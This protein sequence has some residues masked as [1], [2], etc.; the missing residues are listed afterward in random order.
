MADHS[1]TASATEEHGAEHPGF[2]Q[3]L[4]EKLHLG[5]KH[6]DAKVGGEAEAPTHDAP[7]VTK[8]TT[9]DH[10]AKPADVVAPKSTSGDRVAKP[11]AVAVP[12]MSTDAAPEEQQFY[13]ARS[14]ATPDMAS[15]AG[16]E[17]EHHGGVPTFLAALPDHDVPALDSPTHP[18]LHHVAES[19]EAQQGEHHGHVPE[20]AVPTF[21]ASLPDQDIPAEDAQAHPQLHHGTESKELHQGEHHGVVPDGG[22]PTFLAALPDQ[23]IR[24]HQELHHVQQVEHGAP[25]G[26]H[27]G[28]VPTFLA[29]LPDQD[30]PAQDTPTHP[31]LHHVAEQQQ[32]EEHH[33]QVPEDAVPTFLAALPD[34]DIP[35]EDA[36]AHKELHHVEHHHQGPGGPAEV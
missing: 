13:D 33:G 10:V 12:P 11:A 28:G 14:S 3:K 31:E 30:V 35:A 22:V 8:S 1:A 23:D 20:D 32:Q 36:P 19:K 24:A 26:E 4:K 6:K 34:Q 7:V 27:H 2:L 15:L 21:L 17:S 16:H 5:H 29:T 18:E 9:A 25:Q